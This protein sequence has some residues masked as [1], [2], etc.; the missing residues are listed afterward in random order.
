MLCF[1]WALVS[2]GEGQGARGEVW[3]AKGGDVGEEGE[4]EGVGLGSGIGWY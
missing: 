3:Q 2:L 4:N 1:V